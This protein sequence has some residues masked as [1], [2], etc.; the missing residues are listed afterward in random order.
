MKWENR[1]REFDEIGKNFVGK[2]IIIFA[3]G[4]EGR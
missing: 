1:G 4:D 2:D 3:A